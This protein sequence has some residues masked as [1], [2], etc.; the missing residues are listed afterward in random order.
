MVGTY[1]H[2]IWRNYPLQAGWAAAVAAAA[3]LMH[4]DWLEVANQR[5]GM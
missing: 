2:R 4:C 5:Q 3:V 1:A